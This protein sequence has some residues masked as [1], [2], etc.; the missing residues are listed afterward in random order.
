MFA[1]VTLIKKALKKHI[2]DNDQHMEGVIKNI[3]Q[4][5]DRS[6]DCDEPALYFDALPI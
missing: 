6:M 1:V 5:P 4:Q 2:D 3:K